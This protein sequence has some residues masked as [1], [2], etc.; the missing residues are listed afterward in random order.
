MTHLSISLSI[1]KKCSVSLNDR[2]TTNSMS[3]AQAIVTS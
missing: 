2:I 1:L 3:V